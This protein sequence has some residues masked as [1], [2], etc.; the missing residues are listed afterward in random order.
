MVGGESRGMTPHSSTLLSMQP[1]QRPFKRST[2][3]DVGTATHNLRAP[4]TSERRYVLRCRV[5]GQKHLQVLGLIRAAPGKDQHCF[6]EKEAFRRASGGAGGRKEGEKP[7]FCT[8]QGWF[9]RHL[10][11]KQ[12]VKDGGVCRVIGPSPG[13]ADAKSR[14][15][16]ATKAE[17]RRISL[18]A[19]RKKPLFSPFIC[20][21]SAI[22]ALENW[23]IGRVAISGTQSDVCVRRRRDTPPG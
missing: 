22:P 5:S 9:G 13:E 2:A 1:I 18:R 10:S 14:I 3:A 12:P 11:G 16:R 20:L 17:T 6:G 23:C 19:Y 21:I 4:G 15:F 7:L 8:Q